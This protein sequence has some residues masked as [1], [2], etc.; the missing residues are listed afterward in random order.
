MFFK[1]KRK[2]PVVSVFRGG[3]EVS[4]V[5]ISGRV[6]TTGRDWRCDL[7]DPRS[8]AQRY[9][10]V[11]RGFFGYRLRLPPASTAKVTRSGSQLSMDDLLAWGL[12]KR[13]SSGIS[14][15]LTRDMGA[16][17]HLGGSVYRLTFDSKPTAQRVLET[18]PPGSVPLRFRFGA[19]GGSDLVF[20]LIVM[21]MMVAQLTALRSLKNYPIPEITTLRELPRRISR[22]ILEPIQPVTTREPARTPT[23]ESAREPVPEAPEQPPAADVPQPAA[24][25]AVAPAAPAEEP[26]PG[27][28]REAV[29]KRVSD[30]GV[31]GIL[32]GKGSAGRQ[33][34]RGNLSALQIDRELAQSLDQILGEV[35]GITVSAPGP[36][37]G[38]GSGDLD[39]DGTALLGI[40]AMIEGSEVS[41]PVEVTELAAVKAPP[42]SPDGVEEEVRPEERDE[43]S[44]RVISRVVAAHTGAIRY[45]YNRELRRNPALRG[46]IV[47]RFTI[48]AEG[49]VTACEV[50]ET[51]MNW[52]S[53][54]DALVKMVLG[55]QFPAIPEGTVTVSYPLVF[56]PSM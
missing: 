25:K 27:T 28:G 34:G 6:L 37:D 50:E 16:E 44:T 46:K 48:A 9:R 15:R 40:E 12:A 13:R 21:V 33:G 30:M 55:W 3:R 29:R 18:A 23:A 32:T 2:I 19:P 4:R 47:L 20:A 56:F 7:P 26:S 51:E 41:G 8:D 17:I 35:S 11:Q 10:L 38:S 49:T 43:R 45:A 14:L 31:L 1:S 53:L 42:P 54:E 36:G 5:G 52:P 39:G 22:I 24:E